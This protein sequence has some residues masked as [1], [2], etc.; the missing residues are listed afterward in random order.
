[1]RIGEF[2][3]KIA[4]KIVLCRF[5]ERV[6]QFQNIK[7]VYCNLFSVLRSVTF[8]FRSLTTFDNLRMRIDEVVRKITQKCELHIYEES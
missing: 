3:R 6:E 1:M 2:V 5:M 7:M 8:N 4:T